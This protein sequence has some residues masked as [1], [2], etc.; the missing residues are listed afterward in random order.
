MLRASEPQEFAEFAEAIHPRDRRVFFGAFDPDAA[1]VGPMERFGAWF[2]RL[3]AI[4]AALPAGDFRD[5]PQIEA[6]ADGIASELRAVSAAT[7]P[8]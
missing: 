8:A 4:R 1:P 7:A 6:W 3:P 5:W 2:M